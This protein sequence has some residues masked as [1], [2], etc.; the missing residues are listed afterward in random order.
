VRP[1]APVSRVS[2]VVLGIPTE[3][4][5]LFE[6]L[7]QQPLS[8]PIDLRRK[9]AEH[10]TEIEA[11]HRVN[12]FVDLSGAHALAR[13]C[14][15]LLERW[16]SLVSPDRH[17]VNAAISYF[18]SWQDY[19]HDL[20]IGGLDDDKQIMNAVLAHLGIEEAEGALAS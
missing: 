1:E 4:R 11:E 18:V 6:E 9:V 19:E 15:V 3:L 10:V 17:L 20:E 13:Q 14:S 7:V 12:E 2:T 16:D 5:E 8:E